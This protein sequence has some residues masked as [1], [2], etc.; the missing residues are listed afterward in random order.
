MHNIQEAN[1]VEDTGRSM[2]RIYVALDNKQVEFQS[3]MIELEGK[4]NN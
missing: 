2:Q 3:H 4:I 1:A